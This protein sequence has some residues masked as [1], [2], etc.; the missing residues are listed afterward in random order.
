MKSFS[1]LKLAVPLL[2]FGAALLFTPSC[3]AQS[4]I[5]PDHFDGTDSWEIAARTAAPHTAHA[6]A[7][8][9][10]LAKAPTGA[11]STLQLASDRQRSA[12]QRR[13]AA[14]IPEKRKPAVRKSE[15]Q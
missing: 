6:L 3:R 4:E 13:E 12:P 10:Q 15:K 2:G 8:K 14:A 9:N 5:S 1:M 7:S 11:Q